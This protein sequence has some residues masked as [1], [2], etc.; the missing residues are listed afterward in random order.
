M[1]HQRRGPGRPVKQGFERLGLSICPRG[2]TWSRA[3]PEPQ[4][5]WDEHPVL[6]LEPR[7]DS[8]PH[9]RRARDPVHEDDGFALTV[10]VDTEVLT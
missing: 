7:D 1:R 3:V 6:T 10:S 8:T 5:I 4:K 9:G 2:V